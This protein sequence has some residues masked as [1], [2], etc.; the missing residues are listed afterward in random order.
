VLPRPNVYALEP[1]LPEALAFLTSLAQ[2][3]GSGEARNSGTSAELWHE[4]GAIS[5]TLALK[6]DEGPDEGGSLNFEGWKQRALEFLT[7][8]QCD[9]PGSQ[10]AASATVEIE[11]DPGARTTIQTIPEYQYVAATAPTDPTRFEDGLL[12]DGVVQSRVFLASKKASVYCM[13]I[14]GPTDGHENNTSVDD[15]NKHLREVW[16]GGDDD[17]VPVARRSRRGLG[18]RRAPAVLADGVRRVLFFRR[19]HRRAAARADAGESTSYKYYINSGSPRPNYRED[20]LDDPRLK[21]GSK[22]AVM[23][24]PAYHVSLIPFVKPKNLRQELNEQHRALHPN[25]HETMTLSKLRNLKHQLV[26][27]CNKCKFLDVST[28]AVAW[29]Y[30]EQ[31]VIRGRVDKSNRKQIAGTC[32]VLAYKFY[33][34]NDDVED[35]RTSDPAQKED[36]IPKETRE[37]KELLF[38][39]RKLDK[40]DQLDPADV[41]VKEFSVFAWLE[42]WVKLESPEVQ[43]RLQEMLALLGREFTEYYGDE[44]WWLGG[45]R[46]RNASFES[47]GSR[48]GSDGGRDDLFGPGE[49]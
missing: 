10:L 41:L 21:K 49:A 12:R 9:R 33:N 45:L 31:L 40:K 5:S 4:Q 48:S 30:F 13:S 43:L 20:T 29:V 3:S 8:V 22:H 39:V 11:M 24:M 19:P 47:N 26:E 34:E 15:F 38:H 25:L 27:M 1:I 14:L 32:L 17:E 16:V 35:R 23:L 2:E 42:F 28:V 44:A 7:S 37:L 46:T 6:D 18:S 36:Q